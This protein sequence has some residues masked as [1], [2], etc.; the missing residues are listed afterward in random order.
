MPISKSLFEFAAAARPTDLLNFPH[1]FHRAID[2]LDDEA[3]LS[4]NNNFRDRTAGKTNH[5]R[6]A[7]KRFNH[8]Q[9]ERLRPVDWKEQ[10]S[11]AAEQF[12]FF[13]MTNFTDELDERFIQ[14]MLDVF[15]EVV[16]VDA[17]DLGRDLELATCSPGNLD[18]SV[19]AFFRRNPPEKEQIV[20]R[21]FLEAERIRR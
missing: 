15:V 8:D 3:C 17:V 7:G 11:G 14:Q 10:S 13:R 6:P 16:A 1:R 9:S 19:Y 5:W 12:V 21:C 4:F 18:R 20:L 2:I